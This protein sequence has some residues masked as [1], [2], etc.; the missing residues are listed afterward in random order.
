MG[1]YPG[2]GILLPVQYVSVCQGVVYYYLFSTCLFARGWYIITCSVRVCLPGGGILLPV[3]YVSVCQ[4]VV[5][6]Y[7]FSTCLFARGWYIITCWV[8]VCLPGVVYYYLFSTCLF[9]RGWYILTCWVAVCL[10]GGGMTCIPGLLRHIHGP[11]PRR[12]P[13]AYTDGWQCLSIQTLMVYLKIHFWYTCNNLM[14]QQ[15]HD[16]TTFMFAIHLVLI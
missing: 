13:E 16:F 5:Y 11:A 14:K 3:Q 9:A 4:G 10:P 2:G 8:A 1:W 7:L 6:Y 12:A 15:Q